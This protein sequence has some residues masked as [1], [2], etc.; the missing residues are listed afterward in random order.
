MKNEHLHSR[1]FYK[2][3]CFIMLI[4]L[5]GCQKKQSEFFTFKSKN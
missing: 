3:I 4:L 5:S 1:F 2:E